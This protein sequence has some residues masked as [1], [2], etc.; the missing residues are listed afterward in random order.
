MSNALVSV[1][2]TVVVMLAN[3]AQ[4]CIDSAK[5]QRVAGKKSSIVG[6]REETSRGRDTYTV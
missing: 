2:N 5:E 6:S 3:G 4:K 1:L